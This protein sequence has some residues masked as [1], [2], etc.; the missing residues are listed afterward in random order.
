M[1]WRT[2]VSKTGVGVVIWFDPKHGY[3][4]IKPDDGAHDVF[5]RPFV[6][7]AAFDTGERVEY[8][9]VTS[10]EPARTEAFIRTKR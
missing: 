2:A 6:R 10:G 9:L 7:A 8:T 3:G 1:I 4:F 5:V